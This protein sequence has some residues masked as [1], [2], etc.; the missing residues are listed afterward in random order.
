MDVSTKL[1]DIL[2]VNLA[3]ASASCID[4]AVK[5]TINDAVIATAI[6]AVVMAFFLV[7]I[8]LS[9]NKVVKKDAEAVHTASDNNGKNCSQKKE[10]GP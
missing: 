2:L 8:A 6:K 1:A 10:M 5:A 7:T 4:A 9:L 3:C